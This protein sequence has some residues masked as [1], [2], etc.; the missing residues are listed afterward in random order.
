MFFHSIQSIEYINFQNDFFNNDNYG[1]SFFPKVT[2][3]KRRCSGSR[4]IFAYIKSFPYNTTISKNF[5]NLE[6]YSKMSLSLS[7]YIIDYESCSNMDFVSISIDSIIL[8]EI[9]GSDFYKE[10]DREFN[11]CGLYSN[12]D[13]KYFIRKNEQ[14][15]K[16]K[17]HTIII[18]FGRSIN[19][20]STNI[21]NCYFGFRDFIITFSN[22]INNCLICDNSNKKCL[23]CK[24]NYFKFNEENCIKCD[25]SCE[26]C[27]GFNQM[28]CLSCKN[29]SYYYKGFCKTLCPDS[30]FKDNKNC[31]KC[32]AS[33]KECEG[34]S[35][36]CLSCHSSKFYLN[37]KCYAKCP[38]SYFKDNKNC[39]KCDAS[40]K[41]CEGS[42]NKCVSCHSSKFYLN[43]KCYA[44]CPDSYFKDNKNCTKCDASC[45][46]CEGSSNKC[47]SCHSSKF[48]LNK[49][50][51][52]KCPDSYFKDNKNCTKCDASCK[53]CEGSSNNCL[54]CH[55]SKFYLNKKCYAKCP[56]SYFKDNKNCTKCDAS[57][58]ECEGSS[59]NCLSCH[60]SKFYLNKKCYA[61]CPDSYFKDNKNCTKC[62]ANCKECEGSSNNCLSCHSS[63]FYLNKKCYAKCPDSYFKD[64]KN[65]TKC[66]ASCKECDGRLETNCLE[67][68]KNKNLCNDKKCKKYCFVIH[69][70]NFTNSSNP[71]SFKLTFDF[72]EEKMIES[73]VKFPKKYTEISI[74]DFIIG[75]FMY[76]FMANKNNPLILYL[77][78][79][80]NKALV[81]NE[82]L[83][84]T[85]K[86]ETIYPFKLSKYFFSTNLNNYQFCSK[87]YRFN[88]GNAYYILKLFFYLKFLF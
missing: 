6:D 62:D 78:I 34:S 70:V 28:N 86:E 32:D 19:S 63:K 53:E 71:I 22:C 12:E 82:K 76:S 68:F 49:K 72:I 73:F 33:C 18:K 79:K 40:C 81:K 52:A 14:I 77:Q 44:K 37:K 87:N 17:I 11:G 9:H 4:D 39:T 38:D 25:S 21:N 85:I 48:Y 45:K 75:D 61:K 69:Q 64:N 41:E 23:L 36:N 57:C 7:L 46:E 31:T 27:N 66:D 15:S 67:C 60:T 65:C 16:K 42:S 55:S 74:E 88:L 83:N 47:V 8:Y 2:N 29:N 51:Y 58:K 84:F 26:S 56:D 54:S 13:L 24:S 5:T 35:N 20:R 50:C 3:F 30:Y 80:Y 59:N 1:W 43:K 10:S